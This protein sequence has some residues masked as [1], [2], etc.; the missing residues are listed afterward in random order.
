MLIPVVKLKPFCYG[1]I[2]FAAGF[3][4]ATI[5][6]NVHALYQSLSVERSPFFCGDNKYHLPRKIVQV[7][8]C[9]LANYLTLSGF[10]IANIGFVIL[11]ATCYVVEQVTF[12]YKSTI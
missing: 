5:I 1:Y 9:T 12:I 7:S 6:N 3:S 4:V 8:L 2:S 11:I 10:I